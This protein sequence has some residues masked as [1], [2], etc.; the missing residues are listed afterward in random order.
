MAVGYASTAHVNEFRAE[1]LPISE[2]T[3]Q[4][5]QRD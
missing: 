2:I 4:P 5:R 1:R 3:I